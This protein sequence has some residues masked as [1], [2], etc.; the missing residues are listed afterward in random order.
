M[1]KK[2]LFWD[3]IVVDYTGFEDYP[4]QLKRFAKDIVGMLSEHPN[5]LTEP[6]I[7]DNITGGNNLIV[8]ALKLLQENGKVYREGRGVKYRPYIYKV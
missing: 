5:G 6:Y 2:S 4:E 1:S 7:R 3:N 8:S